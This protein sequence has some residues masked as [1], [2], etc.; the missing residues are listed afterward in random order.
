VPNGRY[1]VEAVVG[2]PSNFD[3]VYDLQAEGA[4]FLTGTPTDAI[5]F[6]QGS[7]NVTVADGKLTLSNGP[8]ASNN[9]IAFVDV[10]SLAGEV[11][12]PILTATRNGLALTLAWTG[13]GKLQEAAAISGP[14]TDVAG[15][16]SGSHLT[17]LNPPSRFYRVIVP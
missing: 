13:G 5:R 2:E 8:T 16:P 3:S 11:T 9:K 6:F 12:R 14:W 7:T 1:R 10:I 15:N 17:Q 4:S